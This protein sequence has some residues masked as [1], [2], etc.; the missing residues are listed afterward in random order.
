MEPF[1]KDMAVERE[2]ESGTYHET[3]PIG[4]VGGQAP[5][6][7]EDGSRK[8]PWVRRSVKWEGNALVIESSSH[9]GPSPDEGSWSERREV[10]SLDPDGRL[11]LAITTRSSVDGPKTVTAVY[12]PQ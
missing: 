11:N 9:A 6:L 4:V 8:G 10:W 5:G 7:R 1:F 2:F 3:F 12:R